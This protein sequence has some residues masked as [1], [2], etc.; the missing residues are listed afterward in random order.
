[1]KV[2]T[3]RNSP[4][5]TTS[6]VRNPRKRPSQG[7]DQSEAKGVAHAV[8]SSAPKKRPVRAAA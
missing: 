2:I 4:R 5:E 1:M 7:E 6:A 8:K 3:V